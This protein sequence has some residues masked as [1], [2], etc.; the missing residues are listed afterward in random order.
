MKESKKMIKVI[1]SEGASQK[2]SIKATLVELAKLQ[3]VQKQAASDE[4]KAASLHGKATKAAHRAHTAFLAAKAKDEQAS[5]EERA[6]T[7]QLEASRSY[8]A[9]MTEKIGQETKAYEELNKQCMLDEREREV[10]LAE[11]KEMKKRK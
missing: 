11:L 1:K 8:A 2:K 9:Q 10:K 3:K 6:K 4:S 7:E 5:G